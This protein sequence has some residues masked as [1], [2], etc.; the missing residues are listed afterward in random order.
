MKCPSHD[1]YFSIVMFKGKSHAA[2]LLCG[3]KSNKIK[4]TMVNKRGGLQEFRF[5]LK[6]DPKK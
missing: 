2:C 6:K 5:E 1:K 4:I 3:R